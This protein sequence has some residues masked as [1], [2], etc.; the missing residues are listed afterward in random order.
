MGGFDY[1]LIH[2]A[3]LWQSGSSFL[4]RSQVPGTWYHA[5]DVS[6]CAHFV[7]LNSVHYFSADVRLAQSEHSFSFD[8][9]SIPRTGCLTWSLFA[10]GS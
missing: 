2:L 8:F 9:D 1:I 5:P 7:A 3:W 4:R 6:C 10:S